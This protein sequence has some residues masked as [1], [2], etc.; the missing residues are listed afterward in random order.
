ML[1]WQDTFLCFTYDRPPSSIT[2]IFPV[3]LTPTME[4]LSFSEA[5]LTI[6]QIILDHTRPETSDDALH[7]I[8]ESKRQL[9]GIWSN[10]A[11]F[12]SHKSRCTSLQ[13]HLGRLAL[14]IHLG[15]SMCR[16]TWMYLEA[17][18]QHL[19]PAPSGV[20]MDCAEQA[21]QVIESFLD[22]HRFSANVCRSWAFVHNAVSCA[23]T[24]KS[25]EQMLPERV[26]RAEIIFQRLIAVLEKEEKQSE[27]CDADTNVR[28]FGPYSRALKALREIYHETTT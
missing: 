23:I 21:V 2:T 20:A 1:I 3:P 13:H 11:P 28:Y 7:G 19:S 6:C 5:V 16:P 12:L 26:N 18:K 27:W 9:E 4:G 24:L 22:L 15:Y 25:L 10:V 17:A 14:G 8:L